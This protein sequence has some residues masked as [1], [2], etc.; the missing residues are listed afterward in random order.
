MKKNNKRI[1]L[2]AIVLLVC[3]SLIV[4]TGCTPRKKTDDNEIIYKNMIEESRQAI[5]ILEEEN[6]ELKKENKD[7]QTKLIQAMSEKSEQAT[8]GQALSDLIDIYELYKSGNTGD[9][10]KNLKKIEPMGFDDATLAYYKILKDI[11]ENKQ[12]IN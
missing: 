10:S 1:F 4:I 5:K 7:L 2:F 3:V 6:A 9:A 8:Q 12:A 11:L